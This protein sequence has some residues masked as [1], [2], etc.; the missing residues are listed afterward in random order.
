MSSS[1]V[2][3]NDNNQLVATD[4]QDDTRLATNI[5]TSTKEIVNFGNI[6]ST[7]NFQRQLNQFD[8]SVKFNKILT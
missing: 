7:I 1:F 2:F 6:N 8:S 5:S 4:I 3:I